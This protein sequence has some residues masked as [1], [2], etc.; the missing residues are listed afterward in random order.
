M[1]MILRQF[2]L[3]TVPWYVLNPHR[4]LW[5]ELTA[6]ACVAYF[7]NVVVSR[8]D[9]HGTISIT[10]RGRVVRNDEDILIPAVWTGFDC[11]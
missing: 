9:E 3:Q 8:V 1:A 4:R 7:A 6:Q 5:I 11:I 2:C 10:D